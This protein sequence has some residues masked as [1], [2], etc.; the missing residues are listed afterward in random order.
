MTK[1]VIDF[2]PVGNK[3]EQC[4]R[5]RVFFFFEIIK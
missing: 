2:D 3:E 1:Q 5:I 4:W